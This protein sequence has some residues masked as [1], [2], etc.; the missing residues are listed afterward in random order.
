MKNLFSH[1][2]WRS[3]FSDEQ[4]RML[5]RV[6]YA[7]DEWIVQKGYT[8][9]LQTLEAIAADIGVPPD[10]LSLYIRIKNRKSVLTWRKE[11]RIKEA[12]ELLRNYPELPISVI[13]EMVGIDDKTNFKRQFFQVTGEM[14]R[15]WREKHL[16]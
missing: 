4:R 13:G 1:L 15:D 5:Q 3:G 9:I 12:R 2:R 10:Q 8:K 6:G 11:L 14:P 7:V 16:G